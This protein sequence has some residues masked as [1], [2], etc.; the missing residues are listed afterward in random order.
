M[1]VRS[2]ALEENPSER[3]I[4]NCALFVKNFNEGVDSANK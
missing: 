1:R 3:L 4:Y 2:R